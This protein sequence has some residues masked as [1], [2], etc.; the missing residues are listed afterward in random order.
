MAKRKAAAEIVV[1]P[2]KKVVG[3]RKRK[4][5]DTVE[6]HEVLVDN[7]KGKTRNTRNNTVAIGSSASTSLIL[8]VVY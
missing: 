4:V 8:V 6:Q 7:G 1:S 3:T 5:I 2:V